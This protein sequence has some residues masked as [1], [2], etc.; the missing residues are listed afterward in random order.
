[1]KKIINI[2][3]MIMMIT[4]CAQTLKEIDGLKIATERKINITESWKLLVPEHT[5]LV[6]AVTITR[7]ISNEVYIF[8]ASACMRGALMVFFNHPLSDS[9]DFRVLKNFRGILHNKMIYKHADIG[10]HPM[11]LTIRYT[12]DVRKSF[13]MINPD[14]SDS[15]PIAKTGILLHEFYHLFGEINDHCSDCY[16]ILEDSVYPERISKE[17]DEEGVTK[18][19]ELLIERQKQLGDRI[20]Q[21]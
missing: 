17:L 20:H 2:I 6:R 4:S 16:F 21:Q 18:Y 11:G 12:D 15:F 9:L 19:F 7:G 8:D 5:N 10:T 3:A 14:I 1:M 13:I